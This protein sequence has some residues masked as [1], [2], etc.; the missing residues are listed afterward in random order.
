MPVTRNNS[1][2]IHADHEA[3]IE[4]S[5]E[6]LKNLR[7]IIRAAARHSSWIEK[8]CGV[9]GAQLWVLQE[10][11]EIPGLRVG[12]IAEKLAIHQA[13]A[14]NLLDALVKKEC[15]D[16]L[17]DPNDHRVVRLVLSK[18]GSNVLK[19]GPRSAR[20]LLPEA[21]RKL[22]QDQL[23]KLNKSLATLIEVM[24]IKDEMLGMQPLPFT[25]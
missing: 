4:A 24:D 15:I 25:M 13:T 6:A 23:F 3:N 17:R 11:K 12:Q 8:H 9:T 7:V 16:K 5:V 2:E 21:L 14:S 10:L 22:D 18:K 1:A 20:G 19:K